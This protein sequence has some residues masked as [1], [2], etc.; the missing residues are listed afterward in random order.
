MTPRS[1]S[2]PDDLAHVAAALSSRSP[3]TSA[4]PGMSGQ[5]RRVR[6]GARG[7]LGDPSARRALT[8]PGRSVPRRRA[9]SADR[10]R[11]STGG[12]GGAAPADEL[13]R[14]RP[15]S[16]S[17]CSPTR[18]ATACTPPPLRRACPGEGTRV[19]YLLEV[20]DPCEAT[21]YP[22][23][24][25]TYR[26]FCCRRTTARRP[27]R[28]RRCRTR[29][30]ARPLEIARGY[31]ASSTTTA[32]GGRASTTRRRDVRAAWSGRRGGQRP[33]EYTDRCS[34]E[35]RAGTGA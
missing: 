24:G 21:S 9:P 25:S 22:S 6:Q 16:C 28:T 8:S 27:A 18:G 32:P 26:S 14:P 19:R 12:K 20:G 29:A 3:P 34:R 13:P 2:D 35:Y 11:R 23:A 5:R 1:P 15:T 10:A 17:R 7:H 31:I 4:R 30:G 33:A